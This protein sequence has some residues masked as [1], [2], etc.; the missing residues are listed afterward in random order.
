MVLRLR[1]STVSQRPNILR[2]RTQK[3]KK[4]HLAWPFATNDG[5]PR[6]KEK[7][8]EITQK[9]ENGELLTRDEAKGFYGT[10]PLLH[11]HNFDFIND[12]PAEYMHSGCIGVVR[13]MIELTFNVGENRKRITKRKLCDV[14]MYNMLI[15]IVQS[16]HEFSRRCRN[17]DLGVMKAQEHRNCIL[18]FFFIVVECIGNSFKQEQRLWL[19]L[20]YI[21]RSCVLTNEEYELINE[22]DLKITAKSFYKN[23]ESLYGKNNCTYSVHTIAGHIFQIRGDEPL[24]EKS[25]FKYENFYAEL[26]NLFQPGTISPSKQ[27]LKNCYM[28]RKLE[29]HVC[30]RKNFFD[31]EKNGKENNSLIYYLDEQKKYQFFNIIKMNNNG[32][33]TCNPQGRYPFKSDLL[34]NLSWEKIGVFK[35]GPHSDD[36]IIVPISKI[37]GKVL[38]VQEYFLTCP[39]NV[40]R[41]Q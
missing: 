10:S 28:K 40:L 29:K 23:F 5:P 35:V 34:P 19:Q 26:R 27:I 17:L 41:E 36:E 15:S 25:A 16:P 33:V 14:S 3:K 39:N 2:S 18:F 38:R 11:Q 4:G 7:I 30:K 24:T 31:V 32:T 12:L 21:M 37:Q 20:A 13:R 8:I 1:T 9:I 22:N 6:T